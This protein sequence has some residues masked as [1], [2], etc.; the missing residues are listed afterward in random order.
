MLFL[1]KGKLVPVAGDF[2]PC[3]IFLNIISELE[4]I[5]IQPRKHL[6]SF[7]EGFRLFPFF[8]FFFAIFGE[9]LEEGDAACVHREG[10]GIWGLIRGE[11]NPKTFIVLANVFD[12]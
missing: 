11:G 2:S 12:R 6:E 10:N 1:Q 4:P 8:F 9:V 5:L 7:Q 3:N